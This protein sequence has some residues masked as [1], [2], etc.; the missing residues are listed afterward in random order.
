MTSE[1][2]SHMGRLRNRQTNM[3]VEAISLTAITVLAL[4]VRVRRK[5]HHVKRIN[6]SEAQL[7]NTSY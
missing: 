7:Y 3:T 6:H 5:F 4:P 1:T 2:T